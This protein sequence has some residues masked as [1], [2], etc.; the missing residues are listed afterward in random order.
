M[1]TNVNDKKNAPITQ[2]DRN[3]HTVTVYPN[4]RQPMITIMPKQINTLSEENT[5][6]E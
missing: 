6:G 1:A 5:H 4:G 3:G 2:T